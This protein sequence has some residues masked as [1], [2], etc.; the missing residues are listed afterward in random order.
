[1]KKTLP[2]LVII[3]LATYLIG[4]Y[5]GYLIG[6]SKPKHLSIEEFANI[7]KAIDGFCIKNGYLR[8]GYLVFNYTGGNHIMVRCINISYA[9][10]QDFRIEDIKLS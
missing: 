4:L 8:G 10:R 7:K 5:S 3:Q 6:L 2:L 9:Q 1:M